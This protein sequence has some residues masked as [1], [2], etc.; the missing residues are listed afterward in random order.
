ML[1]RATWA[2]CLSFYNTSLKEADSLPWRGITFL[3]EEMRLLPMSEDVRKKK[4]TDGIK[5]AL[6]ATQCKVLWVDMQAI[7]FSFMPVGKRSHFHLL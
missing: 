5:S 4:F 6:R 2:L 7:I 3:N 1:G